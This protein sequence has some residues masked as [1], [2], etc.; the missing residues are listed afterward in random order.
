MNQSA[1][2]VLTA[3][4]IQ[5]GKAKS[6]HKAEIPLTVAIALRGESGHIIYIPH[7]FKKTD[8][9]LIV[10]VF[11]VINFPLHSLIRVFRHR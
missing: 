11:D 9:D 4:C 2:P 6:Y 5:N 7:V 3:N 10:I 8:Y 1:L